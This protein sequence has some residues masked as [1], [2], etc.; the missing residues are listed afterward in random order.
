MDP[1]TSFPI[2]FVLVSRQAKH[3][4]ININPEISN[5]VSGAAYASAYNLDPNGRMSAAWPRTSRLTNITP[6][7]LLQMRS[8]PQV[9]CQKRVSVPRVVSRMRASELP[10]M[11][12]V[13]PQHPVGR[14]A[15]LD[16]NGAMSALIV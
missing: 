10:H 5:A 9:S 8:F 11:I 7:A 16:L 15:A 2:Q 4:V 14:S 6:S 3:V 1:S 13:A 12:G